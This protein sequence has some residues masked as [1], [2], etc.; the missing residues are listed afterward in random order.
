MLRGRPLREPLVAASIHADPAVTPGLRHDPGDKGVRI[1]AIVLVGHRTLRTACLAPRK[2]LHT[3]VA[4]RSGAP[5]LRRVLLRICVNGEV[6]QRGESSGRLSWTDGERTDTCAIAGGH[7][8]VAVDHVA[9]LVILFQYCR[10]TGIEY[11]IRPH[12]DILSGEIET[13]HQRD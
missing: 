8:D 13:I 3:D 6:E 12:R 10:R 2:P 9:P 1:R 5:S 11:L 4:V 7:E